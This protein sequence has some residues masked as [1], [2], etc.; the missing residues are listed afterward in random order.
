VVPVCLADP[1]S[2]LPVGSNVGVDGPYPDDLGP[3]GRVLR[4]ADRKVSRGAD[5]LWCVVVEILIKELY[6]FR[7]TACHTG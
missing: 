2:H 4:N 1:V 6:N 3:E 5:E 7:K